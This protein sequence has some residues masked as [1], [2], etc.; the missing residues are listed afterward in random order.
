MSTQ[1]PCRSRELKRAIKDGIEDVMK[2]AETLLTLRSIRG[3]T[4]DL[5]VTNVTDHGSVELHLIVKDRTPPPAAAVET[6]PETPL[7]PETNL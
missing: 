6:E 5:I 2:K 3:E 7:F 4:T 1:K